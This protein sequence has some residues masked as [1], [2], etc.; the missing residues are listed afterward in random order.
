MFLRFKTI[1][2]SFIT[3]HFAFIYFLFFVVIPLNFFN[4]CILLYEK[5][6]AFLRQANYAEGIYVL[7]T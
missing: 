3:L 7:S 1:I 2:F 6:K 5:C 4:F